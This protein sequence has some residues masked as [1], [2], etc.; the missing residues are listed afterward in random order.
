MA[1]ERADPDPGVA[2]DG[3]PA[4]GL[5]RR[6]ERGPRD[7]ERAGRGCAARRRAAVAGLRRRRV[8]PVRFRPD[9]AEVPPFVLR[10]ISGGSSASHRLTDG[11]HAHDRRPPRSTHGAGARAPA[12]SGRSRA[13]PSPASATARCSSSG[14]AATA[15]GRRPAAPGR[16]ARRRPH[17]HRPVLRRR[18]RQRLIREAIRARGRRDRRQQGRRRP[19]TRAAR[20][21]CG[22][23]SAREQLRA[24]RRGQPGRASALDQIPRGQPAPGRR[25]PGLRAEG[26]QIVDLDDQLAVMIALRDEGKIGAIG[27]SSVT[28]RRSAPGPP[29]RD[30]LRAERLQPRRPRR[31]GHARALPPPRTSPGCRTSRSAAPSRACRR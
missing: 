3:A 19:R 22:S 20:S 4:A 27:L 11:S 26:D 28:A 25:R 15:G 12:G 29:R 13:A 7:G 8:L 18:L 10:R 6:A 14:C 23:R 9:K 17:R 30:R 1:V 16:R 24:E 31:R 2:G 5:V 21:R